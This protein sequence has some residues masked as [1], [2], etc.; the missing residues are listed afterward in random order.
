[1]ETKELKEKIK[2]EVDNIPEDV[3]E[4][5]LNYLK[6]LTGKSK[7]NILLSQN[8][9]KILYEDKNLLERLAK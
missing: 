6:A 2:K 9:G 4:T 7:K 3:L 5:V 1:M 8:L